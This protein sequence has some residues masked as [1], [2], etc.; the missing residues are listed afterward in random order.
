MANEKWMYVIGITAGVVIWGVMDAIQ[1][2]WDTTD[3]GGLDCYKD[4]YKEGRFFLNHFINMGGDATNDFIRPTNDQNLFNNCQRA[5]QAG[6]AHGTTRMVE[7]V[8][9]TV[10]ASAVGVALINRL[11]SRQRSTASA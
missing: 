1:Y 3:P 6:Y 9:A 5:F 4:G 7:E 11:G 10:A 8:A 2:V